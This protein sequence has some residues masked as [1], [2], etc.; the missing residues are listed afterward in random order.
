MPTPREQFL[1]AEQAK[2]EAAKKAAAAAEKAKK[3]A[4]TARGVAGGPTLPP[5]DVSAGEKE[6]FKGSQEDR[7]GG[8]KERKSPTKNN[9]PRNSPVE[10]PQPDKRSTLKKVRDELNKP[11][12][13]PSKVGKVA[14][15]A[16]KGLG[17]V[18]AAGA[19]V[20]A[21]YAAPLQLLDIGVEGLRSIGDSE[22][23]QARR[24]SQV[25]T[26][27]SEFDGVGGGAQR[28]L[29]A[30]LDPG[31]TL[32]AAAQGI[33]QIGEGD[34]TGFE[35]VD[36][37]NVG[38]SGAATAR[39]M[40]KNEDR[41]NF[42]RRALKEQLG[43]LEGVG[44]EFS[45][46]KFRGSRGEKYLM[47][48]AADPDFVEAEK[49]ALM[50]IDEESSKRT[51]RDML[52]YDDIIKRRQ[53]ATAS[54]ADRYFGPQ[55]RADFSKMAREQPEELLAMFD[56]DKSGDLSE[57]ERAS[58]FDPVSGFKPRMAKKREAEA[59]A[60]AEKERA[61]RLE[62]RETGKTLGRVGG[63]LGGMAKSLGRDVIKAKETG[64]RFIEKRLQG[65]QDLAKDLEGDLAYSDS[66]S[67]AFQNPETREKLMT[68][69]YKRG[70][71][72]G[73]RPAQIRTFLRNKGLLDKGFS[74][75]YE[76][77]YKRNTEGDRLT[78]GK[79][80]ARRQVGSKEGVVS[81]EAGR[82][83]IDAQEI[84]RLRRLQLMLGRQ[85]NPYQLTPTGFNPRF[86]NFSNTVPTS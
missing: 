84:E 38:E 48:R 22:Q 10:G 85:Q 63:M 3:A 26:F 37:A 43:I 50:A 61:E 28:V 40:K 21:P 62:S 55:D 11:S 58:I 8:R 78:T 52:S 35:A 69:A 65:R 12:G 13:K 80:G 76:D 24:K 29:K 15:G 56:D 60:A 19:R 4:T 27:G 14:K 9:V 79:L 70:E 16:A 39:A 67:S 31:G 44:T 71:E 7:K 17:K 77:F 30:Q 34:L 73:L 66:A 23:A 6:S 53:N 75:S 47:G 57:R 41:I 20:A 42:R 1:A 81:T 49:D 46:G 5:L 51:G 72:L 59:A 83:A 33:F 18:A 36:P 68:D 2:R 82:R 25:D 64:E 86:F 45:A 32:S 74:E 54:E